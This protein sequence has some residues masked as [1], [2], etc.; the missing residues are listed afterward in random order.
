[1]IHPLEF[2][3]VSK[4][5]KVR[6]RSVYALNKVNF[7]LNE[8]EVFGFVGPNGAGK[9]TSIKIMLDIINDYQGSCKIYGVNATDATSRR[10]LAYVPEHP[11]LYENFTPLE[12]LEMGLT[13]QGIKRPDAKR[14]C[15]HWLERFSV[16]LS[17][18]KRIKELSK[19]NA[20][21]VAL[22][23]A[24]AISPKLLILD[25][26]LSG[27]DP[28]GRKDVVDILLEF[29]Q[30]GGAIFFTSHVLH[31]VERIADR[32]AFINK[33]ELVTVRSPRDLAEEQA[34]QLLVKYY[35][36]DDLG[37]NSEEL[38][39]D[40]YECE[41]SQSDLPS[42]ITKLSVAGGHIL[43]IKP[44]LTLESVFFRILEQ[45]QSNANQNNS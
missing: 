1:M 21:R 43:R 38:R 20:Q 36:A 31:D 41:I 37:Y 19:G 40:E 22:A 23:H 13:M 45:S 39:T 16:D 26:P 28:V 33:G 3:D 17:S 27:L 4:I 14:W 32:F 10:N 30:N 35:C 15:L 29:K 44:C 11:S 18:K 8:G 12:I 6:G 42:F 25:E 24:L 34:G 5:F 7:A 2:N 9:S